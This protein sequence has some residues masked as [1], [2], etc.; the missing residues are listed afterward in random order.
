MNYFY[1]DVYNKNKIQMLD[2]AKITSID[3]PQFMLFI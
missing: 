1:L 3:F 2:I